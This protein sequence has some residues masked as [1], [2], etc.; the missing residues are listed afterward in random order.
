LVVDHPQAEVEIFEVR[1]GQSLGQVAEALRAKGLLRHLWELKLAARWKGDDAT[2]RAGEY[3]IVRGL[4]PSSLLDLFC[5]GPQRLRRVTLVE[6]WRLDRCVSVLADSI[7]VDT[8]S[9]R[10]LASAPPSTL[11]E[12]VGLDDGESLEGYLF[13]NTYRFAAHTPPERILET[14]LRT[15]AS[16]VDSTM[17]RRM[18]EMGWPLHRV[19]TLA[20]IVEAEAVHDDERPRVAAVYLNRLARG[21][22]LEADPTVAYALKK[23]GQRLSF[24]DLEVDSAYNTY[25]H[26]GLPP[27]PINSPGLA[28]VRAVLW[29]EPDFDAMYF[30]ADGKGRHRFSRTWEEHREAVRQYR[31]SQRTNGH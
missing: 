15:L 6:G 25:V 11:R 21:W 2:I 27:G 14:V 24:R 12:I 13:P 17:H 7:S 18:Q 16:R 19:L 28:S 29:P 26:G 31:K 3:E 9:L 4:S 23:E 5:C 10:S 8:D 30:V 1:P 22:K 20:S